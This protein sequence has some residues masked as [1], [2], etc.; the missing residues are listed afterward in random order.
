MPYNFALKFGGGSNDY[1]SIPSNVI[2]DQSTE[3][4]FEFWFKP[5]SI[6][7]Q[8]LISKGTSS[9]TLSYVLGLNASGKLFMGIGNYIAMNSDGVSL[10]ANKW[11]HVAVTWN[12]TGNNY[13]ICF[14][15]N[16][17]LNGTPVTIFKIPVTAPVG[18][19]TTT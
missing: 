12:K 4:T 5:N 13:Q 15:K 8:V 3:G 14:Y 6:T 9:P 11:N 19:F 16:G 18:T 1:I 7:E 10:D 2:F 17:K